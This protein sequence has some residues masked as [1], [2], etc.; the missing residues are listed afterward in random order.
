MFTDEDY[1]YNHPN[2]VMWGFLGV[3]KA[4]LLSLML[5]SWI[6]FEI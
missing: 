3:V 4:I 2:S 6:G 1:F 5:A